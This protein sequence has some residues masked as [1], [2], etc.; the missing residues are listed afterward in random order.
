MLKKIIVMLLVLSLASVMGCGRKQTDEQGPDES[1]KHDVVNQ[2][3]EQQGGK[4]SV[5]EDSVLIKSQRY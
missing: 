3:D 1:G 5:V 2:D 4:D